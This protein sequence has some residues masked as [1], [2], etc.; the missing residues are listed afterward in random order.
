MQAAS[1]EESHTAKDGIKSS[2]GNILPLWWFGLNYQLLI[3]NVRLP[4]S[5]YKA[6]SVCNLNTTHNSMNYSNLS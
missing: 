2:S 1:D 5:T 6:I 4:T 3:R